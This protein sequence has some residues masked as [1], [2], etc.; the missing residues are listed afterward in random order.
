MSGGPEGVIIEIN[1][2]AT[3]VRTR[4]G[5]LVVVP[6]GVLAKSV[7]ANHYWPSPAHAVGVGVTFGND[8]NPTIATEILLEAGRALPLALETPAPSVCLLS[9]GP[10][11][12][13]YELDFYVGDYV[14]GPAA[15]SDAL[16][17]IWSAAARRDVTFATPRQ[18][19]VVNRTAEPIQSVYPPKDASRPTATEPGVRGGG[20]PA[21]TIAASRSPA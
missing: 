6:N 17:E 2:R 13:A 1:W 16:R 4:A 21:A 20:P 7:V 11:G 5:D 3:R 9:A 10:L 12:I 18:E 15:V 8:V 14:D 19:I